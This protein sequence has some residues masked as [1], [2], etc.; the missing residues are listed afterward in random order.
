MRRLFKSVALDEEELA[1]LNNIVEQYLIFAESQAKR[2][3]TMF[4]LDWDKKL[5]E[6]LKLNDRNILGD[7]GK[8]SHAVSEAL[9]LGEYEK[10]RVE[11]DKNY[12]SDFD[13]V[14]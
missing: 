12:V 3:Q 5:S 2:K 7:L 14:A 4:M 10:Y 8:V 1:G 6:F 11:Q 13:E 9:A